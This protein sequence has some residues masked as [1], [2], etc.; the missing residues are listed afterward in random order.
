MTLSQGEGRNV[1]N[2]DSDAGLQGLDADTNAASNAST[3]GSLS[4]SSSDNKK[5]D[6][7]ESE[8]VGEIYRLIERV[9]E[10]GKQPTREDGEAD[11]HI[12]NDVDIPT[13]GQIDRHEATLAPYKPWCG[14][15]NEGLPM[16]DPHRD[17]GEQKRKQGGR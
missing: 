3:L 15:C 4:H 1:R 11:V 10:L 17:K 14:H 5:A 6:K 16:T 13:Q 7:D 12:I 2:P 9:G 8:D